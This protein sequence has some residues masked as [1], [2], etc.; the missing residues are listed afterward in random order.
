MFLCRH[1]ARLSL[2]QGTVLAC[3]C[4]CLVTKAPHLMSSLARIGD[5]QYLL[6]D[7]LWSCLDAD[8]LDM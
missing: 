5:Q 7:R 4:S 3:P 1:G 6:L 2:Q 8:Y